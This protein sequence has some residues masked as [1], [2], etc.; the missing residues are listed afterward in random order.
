MKVMNLRKN[1]RKQHKMIINT[2][3]KIVIDQILNLWKNPHNNVLLI[4]KIIFLKN[5]NFF[6]I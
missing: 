6:I 4:Y 5:F 3:Y 2:Q 1:K